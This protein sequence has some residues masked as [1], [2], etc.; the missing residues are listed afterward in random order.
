MEYCNTV[1]A[2]G[3]TDRSIKLTKKHHGQLLAYVLRHA[4]ALPKR[5]KIMSPNLALSN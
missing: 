3:P 1:V 5:D 4:S 2:K